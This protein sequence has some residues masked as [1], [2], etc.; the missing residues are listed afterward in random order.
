[1]GIYIVKNGFL[2]YLT[3]KFICQP[4]S[5]FDMF[6][7]LYFSRSTFNWKVEW[8]QIL[9]SLVGEFKRWDAKQISN[10]CLKTPTTRFKK[11]LAEI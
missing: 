4:H 2:N 5:K 8:G 7:C 9:G 1:M 10:S 6:I 3:M 11:K